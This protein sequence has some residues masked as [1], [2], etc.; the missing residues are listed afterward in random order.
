MRL[1]F[2]GEASAPGAMRTPKRDHVR[3]ATMEAFVGCSLCSARPPSTRVWTNIAFAGCLPE[4][5]TNTRPRLKRR[6][7]RQ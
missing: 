6:S 4:V 7:E 5:D 1:L 3:G 2:G